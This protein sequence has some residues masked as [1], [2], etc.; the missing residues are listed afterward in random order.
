MRCYNLFRTIG[1]FGADVETNDILAAT[2]FFEAD[3]VQL[4]SKGKV[5]QDSCL[6]YLTFCCN[7]ISRF[8]NDEHKEKWQEVRN[9][10]FRRIV[11][12]DIQKGL[13]AMGQSFERWD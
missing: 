8:V 13:N 1:T 5:F 6:D 4:T 10:L 3:G 12:Q 11:P 9:A 2:R 7:E